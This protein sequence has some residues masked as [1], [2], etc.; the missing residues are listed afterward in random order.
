[1]LVYLY[2]LY[3]S[4]YVVVFVYFIDFIGKLFFYFQKKINFSEKFDFF[5]VLNRKASI[6]P[7]KKDNIFSKPTI[8][9]T[10]PINRKTKIRR[11]IFS[12]QSSRRNTL[13]TTCLNNDTTINSSDST[14][15]STTL[16]QIPVRLSDCASLNSSQ[17]K[18]A[19]SVKRITN[20]EKP[21]ETGNVQIESSNHT[22]NIQ[23]D[24]RKA[25]SAVTVRRINTSIKNEIN[26]QSNIVS[27]NVTVK[28]LNKSA[29]RNGKHN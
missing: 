19:V 29:D 28:R 15:I 12:S 1:M 4:L 17:P 13:D 11:N 5:F 21:Q 26:N 18:S 3:Y 16:S 2:W 25:D 22:D 10:V 6:K 27:P 9:D 8:D 24:P 7:Y 20:I 14:R 23:T